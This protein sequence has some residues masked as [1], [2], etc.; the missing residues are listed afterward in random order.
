MGIVHNVITSPIGNL[1]IVTKDNKLTGVYQDGQSNYPNVKELGERDI[2]EAISET[3]KQL[4]EY[5]AG[6]RGTFDLPLAEAD[7]EFKGTVLAATQE[8]PYGEVST[9]G[10]LADKMG[11][12]RSTV[13]VAGALNTNKL[14]IVI[15]C[16]R[17]IGMKGNR[18]VADVANKEFLQKLEASHREK[19]APVKKKKGFLARLL[20]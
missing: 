2:N 19:F 11:K 17:V 20:G 12:S 13:Y 14:S 9:Y 4:K 8:I 1:T 5:F 18:Y 6:E 7:T 16:H 15:P 3:S 10:D